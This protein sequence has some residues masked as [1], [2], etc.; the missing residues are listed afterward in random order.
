MT[1]ARHFATATGTTMKTS[2]QISL[3]AVLLSAASSCG[4]KTA[5]PASLNDLGLEAAPKEVQE[6]FNFIAGR[7]HACNSMIQAYTKAV[8]ENPQVRDLPETR[9]AQILLEQ[10]ISVHSSATKL[11][12]IELLR[13]LAPEDDLRA[14]VILMRELFATQSLIKTSANMATAMQKD[15]SLGGN[16]RF[17]KDAAALLSSMN[18]ALEK[19]IQSISKKDASLESVK[20]QLEGLGKNALA[21]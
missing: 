1:C 6:S 17:T 5:H 16:L 14:D 12:G 10:L 3:L 20:T 9:I 11:G 21:E 19:R 18:E 8:T 15:M 2:L 13:C 4:N 7:V